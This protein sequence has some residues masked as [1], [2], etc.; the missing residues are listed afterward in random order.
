MRFL[1]ILHKELFP[2]S[3]CILFLVAE[4]EPF[5]AQSGIAHNNPDQSSGSL[6]NVS[7]WRICRRPDAANARLFSISS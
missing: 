1:V 3:S 5:E 2:V 4:P 6:Q 7:I